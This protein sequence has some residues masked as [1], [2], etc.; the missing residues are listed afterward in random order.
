MK[1]T[2]SSSKFE[3]WTPRDSK[4][5]SDQTMLGVVWVPRDGL[6]PLPV[7]ENVISRLSGDARDGLFPLP[8]EEKL[9]SGPTHEAQEWPVGCH[10]GPLRLPFPSASR[11]K[12]NCRAPWECSRWPFP[13]ACQ[14]KG[15]FTAGLLAGW[16]ACW[17]ASWLPG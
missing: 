6:F 13:P 15:A 17:L 12:G 16:L 8:V 7:E 11:G 4:T 10:L 9:I 2:F 3:F 14:G 1:K 5:G